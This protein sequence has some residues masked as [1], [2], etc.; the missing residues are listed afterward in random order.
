VPS[1]L[2]ESEPLGQCGASAST[3]AP[4]PA[5]LSEPQGRAQ[6]ARQQHPSDRASSHEPRLF[7]HARIILRT[8]WLVA[9]VGGGD[10]WAGLRRARGNPRA[11]RPLASHEPPRSSACARVLPMIDAYVYTH[12]NGFQGAHRTRGVRSALP[13]ELD[14]YHQGKQ[15][16]CRILAI[17]PNTTGPGHRGSRRARRDTDHDIRVRRVLVYLADKTG[18]LLAHRGSSNQLHGARVGV[19]QTRVARGRC[20]VSW[21]ILTNL[22]RRRYPPQSSA[23]A[24]RTER[25]LRVL[26][27]APVTRGYLAGGVFIADILNIDL[28]ARRQKFLWDGPEPVPEP[29]S[30]ARRARAAPRLSARVRHEARVSAPS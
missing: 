3:C 12:T 29:L 19:L 1:I 18:K 5:L 22:R 10:C 6:Q 11:A 8:G 17:N 7:P 9:S 23:S 13:D 20:L 26:E 14:R 25:L 21:A 27:T 2:S 28:A 15:L 16:T 24:R 4:P 30:L